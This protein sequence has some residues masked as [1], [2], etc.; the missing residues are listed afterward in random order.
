MA[1]A[2]FNQIEY[3]IHFFS[4]LASGSRIQN[5]YIGISVTVHSRFSDFN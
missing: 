2:S 5:E 3:G 1:F 4:S